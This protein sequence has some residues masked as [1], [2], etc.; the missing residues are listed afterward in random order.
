MLI[1]PPAAT[2][3]PRTVDLRA[4]LV[5]V[6]GG[7]AG[8]CAAITAA[9]AGLNVILCHDRPVL[10]G[11]ASSEVRLWILGAT[12]H[13]GSN[14][15]WAREGGV[16]DEIIVEN[17][18]RNPEGNPVLVDA[19]LLE[20]V[21]QEPN[22][23][24]LLNT[25]AYEVLK[26]PED[27]DRIASVTAF[28]PQNSARYR[29]YAPCFLDSSGDGIVGFLAGAAFRMGAEKREEFGEGFAPDGDF[30]HLL[31]HSIYF[32]SRDTGKPV[33]FVPPAFALKNVPERIPRYRQFSARESGCHLWWIEWGGRLDTVHDTETI[34]WELWKVVYS[35]WDYIKNSGKFPEAATLTLEWVGM[36]PG[37]RESRRFEGDYMLSQNDVVH[38]P[39]HADAVAFG[40][41]S[42]DLHPA[43][44]VYSDKASSHHLHSKGIYGIPYRCLYSR[45]IKNLFLGGRIISASHVAFGT[46][47]VMGTG[48]HCG[49]A[50]GLAA[51][52][53]KQ[54][55]CDPAQLGAPDRMSILQ[56]ELMRTGQHI[57][58]L[59]LD[60][61]DDLARQA[62]I[63]ASSEFQIDRLPPDGPAISLDR[64]RGQLFPL[65]AGQAPCMTLLLDVACDTDI[66]AELRTGSRSDHHTPDVLLATQSIHIA[67]GTQVPLRL[68][69]NVTLDAPRYVLLCLR[70]NPHV[71]V[72]T[73]QQRITGFLQ[74][75]KTRDEKT[76][77]IGGED[78]EVWCPERRPGGQS[79]A[80]ACDPP[81]AAF[82][83]RN[84]INGLQ[85]PTNA[86][87]AWAA[88]IDDP[89][90]SLTLR[91]PQPQTLSR[92]ELFFDADSDHPMESVLFGQPERAVPYCLKSFRLK[93]ESGAILYSCTDNHQARVTIR[94]KSP[95]TTSALTLELLENNAQSPTRS[96][97]SLFEIRCYA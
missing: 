34:K 97:K 80:L 30:G 21:Q 79:L 7:M 61:P 88:R 93:D 68:N 3:E 42:I 56:R 14:N 46:I 95:V 50:V 77:H 16:I 24:L 32:Y 71:S 2:R 4:E 52:L 86:T 72:H 35:V 9:R 41:W 70:E 67:A 44:G 15:R 26:S 12:C 25:A 84:V 65:S 1:E 89:Q 74:L 60:D 92:V 69:F 66:V 36:V 43:D 75:A 90:S 76:S 87:N 28:C 40:G 83:S 38:R 10:G 53:C 81:V 94:L 17:L 13:G 29:L 64:P 23:T 47:R 27:P 91:W 48:A 5:I 96:P 37:K 57:P 49:Q 54:Y 82:A 63:R 6:G 78:Y 45:N 8:I 73:T 39:A 55:H 31:G 59:S 11:N 51:A 22:I 85:R 62:D 58:G 20:K 18:Y 33:T 19:L